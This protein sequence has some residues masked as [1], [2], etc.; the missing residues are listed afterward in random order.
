VRLLLPAEPG[1]GLDLDAVRAAAAAGAPVD[2]EVLVASIA[3]DEERFLDTLGALDDVLEAAPAA[4]VAV[5]EPSKV[6]ED[7]AARGAL[8]AEVAY[9]HVA[10]APIPIVHELV[11]TCNN[12]CVHCAVVDLRARRPGGGRAAVE[13][14]LARLAA[15]GATRVM[16]GVEE[17]GLHPD[18]L[19]FLGAAWRQGFQAIHVVTNGRTYASGDLAARAVAAGATHFQVAIHGPDAVTHEAITGVAGSFAEM[20]EGVRRLREAGAE[21]ITNTIVSRCNVDV[22]APL[23]DR[24]AGLGV[25][26]ALL[27]QLQLQGRALE[28][29]DELLVPLAAAAPRMVAAAEHGETLGL[30]VGLAGVPYC[31]APGAERFLGVDDLLSAYDADPGQPAPFRV[32]FVRPRPCVR[33]AAYAICRGL[34]ESYLRLRGSGEV[35]PLHGPRVTRRPPAPV[36][37]YYDLPASPDGEPR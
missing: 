25:R 12:R 27:T 13:Q 30:R 5:I 1:A 18:F 24:V 20:V 23:M 31:L 8:L 36:A 16:F 32:N 6:V 33:C 34:S 29:A 19:H 15:T 9:R 28:R 3:D 35:R 21:V 7:V 37:A 17:L 26:H 11:P 14:A 10:P 4:Q 2:V 22:L